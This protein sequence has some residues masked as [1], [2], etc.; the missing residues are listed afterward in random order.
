[1][2]SE[3]RIVYWD[4]LKI[5]LISLV[6]IGHF[7]DYMSSLRVAGTVVLFA[8]AFHMQFFFFVSGIF[9]KY[10][11][12]HRFRMDRVLYF[13]LLGLAMKA[14]IYFG[15]KI[16]GA[17]PKWD[18]LTENNV[19]WFMF[20]LAAYMTVSYLLRRVS[21]KIVLPVAIALAL[22][23][24][25]FDFTADY[26]CLSRML[27][28]FPFYYAGFCIKPDA[29]LRFFKRKIVKILGVLFLIA[30]FFALFIGYDV[31][32]PILNPVWY[33]RFTYSEMPYPQ[34][35]IL[36]RLFQYINAVLS[37]VG[38]G[39]LIPQKKIFC[40]SN[41]GARTVPVYAM[42]YFV[43]RII[44]AFG[45]NDFLVLNFQNIGVLI[46][47]FCAVLATLVLS[48]PVFDIPFKL[49]QKAVSSII[50]K[51]NRRKAEDQ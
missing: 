43:L 24:G 2:A 15:E 47:L 37:I 45:V 30:L 49:M 1:M 9:H 8:Y 5:F 27:V 36:L 29:V 48:L 6:V 28:F 26:F 42:H 13:V 39:A 33:A 18:F 23:A 20:V 40:L 38:I 3:N 17:N 11:E 10:D 14:A 44:V 4:N 35:G 46:W 31:L 19:P 16:A 22:A 21:P 50:F 32:S 7:A 34:Y 12:K 41:A 51:L 25:Y